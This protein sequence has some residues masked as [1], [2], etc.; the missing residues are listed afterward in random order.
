MKEIVIIH[1]NSLE[2]IPPVL[3]MVL[4][5]S[6]LGYS[7]S[8]ITCGIQECNLGLLQNKEI[9]VQLVPLANKKL[10]VSKIIDIIRFRRFVNKILAKKDNHKT[11][12][13]IE[14]GYTVFALGTRFKRRGFDFILFLPE[15]LENVLYQRKAVSKIIVDAKNVLVPEYNR[16]FITKVW[17]NLKHIPVVLP[18]KPYFEPKDYDPSFI[19]RYKAEMDLFKHK[20]VILYQGHV[21]ASRDITAV[22]QAVKDLGGDYQMVLLGK[23]YGIM[24]HY[25]S[26]DPGVIHIPFIPAPD[27]LILTRMAYIGVL[28]YTPDLLNTAFCAPNKIF[29]YTKYGLPVIGNDIPGLRYPL[30]LHG[31]GEIADFNN[32]QSVRNA[33][34]NIEDNYYE[35]SQRSI[36]FFNSVDNKE[37]IRRVL[38]GLVD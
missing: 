29:E 1:K 19:E 32:A 28:V 31:I 10:I 33:I 16:S 14:G 6:E 24:N 15:L 34:L 26:I 38:D 30:E 25:R 22:V 13:I 18:N 5:I 11:L 4:N 9:K 37:T 3:S 2:A 23:D 35:Y 8:L 7:V 12:L 17:F 21:S 20:K 27:Y 36:E